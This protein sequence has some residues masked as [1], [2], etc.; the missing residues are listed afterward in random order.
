MVLSAINAVTKAALSPAMTRFPPSLVAAACLVKARAAMGLTP[1]WP[2]MLA[3]MTGLEERMMGQC[4][5]MLVLLGI[6]S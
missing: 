2:G 5:E 1:T 6:A 3:E 4:L